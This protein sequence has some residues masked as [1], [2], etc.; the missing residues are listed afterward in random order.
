M[1]TAAAGPAGSYLYIGAGVNHPPPPATLDDSWCGTGRGNS[2]PVCEE[3]KR[4]K[5]ISAAFTAAAEQAPR[6]G[7]ILSGPGRNGGR[8]VA[9]DEAMTGVR[10]AIEKL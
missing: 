3:K 7:L 4:A 1:P 8:W 6:I 9:V 2:T 10:E 5:K